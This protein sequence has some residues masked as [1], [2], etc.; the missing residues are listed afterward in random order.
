MKSTTWIPAARQQTLSGCASLFV[1]I[2][3][4]LLILG[5]AGNIHF[6]YNQV[7]VHSLERFFTWSIDLSFNLTSPFHFQS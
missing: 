1:D 4:I 2:H 6:A 5:M 7:A 3:I